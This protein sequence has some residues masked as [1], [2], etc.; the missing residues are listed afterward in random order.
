MPKPLAP[1]LRVRGTPRPLTAKDVARFAG[2]A[3][4]PLPAGW[5]TFVTKNGPGELA[6]YVHLRGM[7]KRRG[8]TLTLPQLVEI[9]R[10]NLD[11][12]VDQYGAKEKARLARLVPFGDTIGGDVI[13]WDPGPRPPGEE[14]VEYRVL[15][16][17]HGAR[18]ILEVAPTFD[19]FVAACVSPAFGKLVGDPEWAPERV[20]AAA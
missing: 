4:V 10:D 5:R 18:K 7:A 15:L 14:P 20:F 9:Y 12:Y 8:V 17:R 16:L 13:A 2:I 3:G 6:G 11:V 1:T 19:A